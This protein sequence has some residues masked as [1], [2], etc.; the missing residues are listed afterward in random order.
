MASTADFR[1]GMVIRYSHALY[2]IVEFQHVKPGKGGAF[3]R[4]KLKNVTTGKV[5]DNTFRAGEKV[6]EVRIEARQMQYLYKE[7][8]SFVFMDGETYDQFNMGEELISENIANYLKEGIDYKVLFSEGN[9]I[10]VELPFFME[11]E[12]TDTEHGEKGDRVSAEKKPATLESGAV[13]PVPLFV[14]VGDVIRIDTRTDT[15]IER[16]KK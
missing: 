14:N 12:I 15:Y 7:G 1:N 11:L 8:D 13:V 6:D 9:P 5:I 4:T 3:V 2:T 10:I 16:I